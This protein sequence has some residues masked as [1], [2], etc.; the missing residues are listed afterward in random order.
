MEAREVMRTMDPQTLPV[1]A[2]DNKS[3]PASAG[4]DHV[5]GLHDFMHSETDAFGDDSA[6]ATHICTRW[7]SKSIPVM[8]NVYD[9]DVEAHSRLTLTINNVENFYG[10]GSGRLLLATSVKVL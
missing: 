3:D 4:L 8:Y 7:C 10:G 2:R 6:E 5:R 9:T 1:R